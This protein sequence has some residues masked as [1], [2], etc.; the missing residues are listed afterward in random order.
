MVESGSGEETVVCPSEDGNELA[1]SI[2]GGK[3]L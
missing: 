3:F 2:K 1:G